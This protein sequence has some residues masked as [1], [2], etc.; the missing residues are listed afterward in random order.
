MDGIEVARY[1]RIR[2]IGER[3]IEHGGTLGGERS[4]GSKLGALRE[5]KMHCKSKLAK[6][7][8]R[9]MLWL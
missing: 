7:F 9:S 5:R 8:V 2:F 1:V 4:L 3:R 6:N